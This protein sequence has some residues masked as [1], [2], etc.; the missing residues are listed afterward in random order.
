MRNIAFSRGNALDS[1]SCYAVGQPTDDPHADVL[2][3][4]PSGGVA[5]LHAAQTPAKAVHVALVQ[6]SMRRKDAI[7]A[8]TDNLL[9]GTNDALVLV[10]TRSR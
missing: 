7:G 3:R 10:Q 8:E 5:A 2:G 6:P 4:H 9:D 1:I